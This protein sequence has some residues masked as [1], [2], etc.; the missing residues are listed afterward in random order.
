MNGETENGVMT[1]W[2]ASAFIAVEFN[3]LRFQKIAI[4]PAASAKNSIPAMV[5]PAI[6]PALR[7]V[8]EA[9]VAANAVEVVEADE[10]AEAA[11]ADK[12]VEVGDDAGEGVASSYLQF[13]VRKT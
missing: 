13:C 11:A 5:A 8:L 2:V 4:S 6:T 3:L 9:A 12:A 7:W 10:A 1:S